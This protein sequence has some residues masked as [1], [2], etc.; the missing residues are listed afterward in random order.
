MG[1]KVDGKTYVDVSGYRVYVCC[2]GCVDKIEADPA[3]YL[4]K[5][6]A[7]GETPE[8]APKVLCG[9]CG[10]VKGTPVCCKKDALRCGGCGLAKGSPG[11]C[12]L[13]ADGKDAAL[14]GKCGQVKG[15]AECCKADVA[16]CTK[17]GLAKG[18]P[19]CRL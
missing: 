4:A 16:A 6:K 1:G 17:C 18:S 13:P 7:S 5:I 12:K 9:K 3:K 19:G 10:Q 14:C 15:A 2:A 11:C 8:A